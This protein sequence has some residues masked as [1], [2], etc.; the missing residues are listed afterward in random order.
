MTYAIMHSAMVLSPCLYSSIEF[1]HQTTRTNYGLFTIFRK[2]NQ[3]CLNL[4]VGSVAGIPSLGVT[5]VLVIIILEAVGKAFIIT[6]RLMKVPVE[7]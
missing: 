3:E 1:N 2:M 7:L 4:M 5:L 6:T